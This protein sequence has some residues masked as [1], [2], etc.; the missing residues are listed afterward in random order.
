MSNFAFLAAEFPAVHEAARQTRVSPT[1][2]AF[3][4]GKAVEVAVNGRSAAI[5]ISSCPIRTISPRCCT[6]RAFAAGVPK[7]DVLAAKRCGALQSTES[8]QSLRENPEGH[9]VAGHRRSASR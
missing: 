7:N 3:F 1:A 6:S 5:P 2:A 9:S 8:R 4:A